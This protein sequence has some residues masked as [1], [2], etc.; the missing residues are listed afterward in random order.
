MLVNNCEVN[1][2]GVRTYSH[3][4]E[5]P[6]DFPGNLIGEFATR[7]RLTVPSPAEGMNLPPRG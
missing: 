3:T 4:V 2:D 1:L 5:V 6:F 7:Y